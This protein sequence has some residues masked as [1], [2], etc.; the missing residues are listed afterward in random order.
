MGNDK[1]I[2]DKPKRLVCQRC[3]RPKRN[4]CFCAALPDSPLQ[5]SRSHC[6]VLVH[7]LEERRSNRSLPFVELC[8]H[9]ESLSI[10]TGRRFGIDSPLRH[11]MET[12]RDLW[13]IYPDDKC[14]LSLDEALE[15][16]K[17]DI[18]TLVFLDATWKV[19]C[20]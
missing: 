18:V 1:T 8:L 4:A 14:A 11:K 13:L 20:M 6:I 15:Q 16:R 2:V 7:P 5:L 10:E 12:S 19:R 3:S 17:G 9:K